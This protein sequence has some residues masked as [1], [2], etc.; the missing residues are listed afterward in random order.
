M[1]SAIGP[2]K[3]A[4]T[5]AAVAPKIAIVAKAGSSKT[6]SAIAKSAGPTSIARRPRASARLPGSRAVRRARHPVGSGSGKAL[7]DG[8]EHL[9][10]VTADH[11]VADAPAVAACD[12]EIADLVD[13]ADQRDA[14]LERLVGR[15]A[16]TGGDRLGQLLAVVG[17]RG[18]EVPDLE[19]E[20]VEAA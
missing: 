15:D 5:S 16:E 13:R 3:S 2:P 8:R 11:G 14:G 10:L 17:D 12:H 1:R 9:H 4:N 18:E 6:S 20:V 7:D 19:L